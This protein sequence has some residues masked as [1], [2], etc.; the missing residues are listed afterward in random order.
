VVT[1]AGRGIGRAEAFALA[2]EG[3]QVLVNDLGC[4]RDGTGNQTKV[5]DQVVQEIQSAGGVAAPDYSDI[6]TLDGADRLIWTALSKFGRVDI[7][8]NN[9][10]ILRDRTLL[11]MTEE[12]WDIIQRVHLKGTFLCTRAAAR[13]LKTQGNGGSIINTTS[14]SGLIGNFGQANYSTAK[15]GIYGFTRT[16]SM[17]LK[18]Y[19]IRVNAVC[20][21]ALT[22]MTSDV[23]GLQ[24]FKEENLSPEAIAQVVVFLA[25]DLSR[26]I[27]GR[28]LGVHGGV[29]GGK[30]YE[31]K[32][33][34]S[35]GYVN[36][37]GMISASEMADH[38]ERIL[39]SG[40]DIDFMEVLKLE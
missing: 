37:S 7:L 3:A 33:T 24:G 18:K 29:K 8:V 13:I 11:N 10:G 30:V 40:P 38:L 1:G 20:P 32:M 21:N 28:I 22:R 19:G 14:T 9:A 16:T 34:V 31:F 12:E 4:E 17:E 39:C 23:P 26:E 6:S 27:T 36:Q 5:A 25:S 15:S 35:E 2:R